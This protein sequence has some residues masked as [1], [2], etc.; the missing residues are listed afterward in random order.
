MNSPI[1]FATLNTMQGSAPLFVLSIR[2][3]LLGER[4]HPLL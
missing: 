1:T 3:E 2:G 4:D